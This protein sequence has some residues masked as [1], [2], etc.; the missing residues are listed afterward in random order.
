MIGT[1]AAFAQKTQKTDPVQDSKPVTR[2]LFVFDASQSMYGRWQSDLK[3]NIARDILLKVLD[4]LRP[5]PN[6]EVALRLYG[7]Q[8]R[9]PPQVCDDSKLE[10][11]FAKDNYDK[12]RLKLK[13]VI[14][15]GPTRL[16]RRWSRL[17]AISPHAKTAG[18]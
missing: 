16:L 13:D 1:V 3:I 10:V 17:P 18:M 15:G 8:H 6:L 5:M 9:F 2:I 4:S 14:P 12:I 11:P 7:H